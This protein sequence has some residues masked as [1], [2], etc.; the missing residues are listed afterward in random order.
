M[1][2]LFE[3]SFVRIKKSENEKIVKTDKSRLEVIP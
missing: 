3:R 1:F 2:S